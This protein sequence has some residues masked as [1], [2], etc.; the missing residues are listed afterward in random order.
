MD[1]LWYYSLKFDN[2]IYCYNKQSFEDFF[3]AIMKANNDDFRKV[4]PQGKLGD[5]GCDGYI[6]TTRTFYMCYSPELMNTLS[7]NQNGKDKITRDLERIVQQW[8]EIE[9]LRY[10]FN[11]KYFG[12]GPE[13]NQL[14][15]TLIEKYKKYDL[16][17]L[18]IESLKEIFLNLPTH[19]KEEI[20]GYCPDLSKKDPLVETFSYDAISKI[21]EYLDKNTA[22][23]YKE[24]QLIVPD[25]SE[26]IAFNKLSDRVA[27]ILNH[28]KIY[29]PYVEEFF[30]KNQEYDKDKL[31]NHLSRLYSEAC[32]TIPESDSNYADL[33]FFYLF[34][35]ICFNK[36]SRTIV[37]NTFVIIALFFESCDI[38]EA[39]T[40][41]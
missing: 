23:Y 4:K 31:K 1:D 17:L 20:V 39:P 11:D 35:C 13:L 25:L 9:H 40:N 16:S 6:P 14:I 41:A 38:F 32:T 15:D 36:S 12:I 3:C 33:R 21:I 8:P 26:K 34:D 5:Y 24:D 28:Q 30:Y 18:S 10:V 27:E 19:K 37:D 7:I 2:C 29:I 22:T